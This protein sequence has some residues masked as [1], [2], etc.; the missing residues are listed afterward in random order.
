MGR[1]VKKTY[2][3]PP[4]TKADLVREY[5]QAKREAI[6]RGGKSVKLKIAS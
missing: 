3:Y 5:E 4:K 6:A 2:G 1:G